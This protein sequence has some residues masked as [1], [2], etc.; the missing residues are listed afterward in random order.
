MWV[1]VIMLVGNEFEY[2]CFCFWV[3]MLLLFMFS[4][5]CFLVFDYNRI[6]DSIYDLYIFNLFFNFF[7][8]KYI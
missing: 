3:I 1:K 5:I 7:M 6:C 2:Y 4:I 8:F